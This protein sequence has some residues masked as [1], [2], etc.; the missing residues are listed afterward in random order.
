MSYQCLNFFFFI[1]Y[2]HRS[3]QFPDVSHPALLL[4]CLEKKIHLLF[5]VHI[6][7][8]LLCIPKITSWCAAT[9]LLVRSTLFGIQKYVIFAEFQAADLNC[10]LSLDHPLALQLM[11]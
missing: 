11:L 3:S 5:Y 1:F 7:F 10:L 2:I 9:S 6:E 4:I 8:L